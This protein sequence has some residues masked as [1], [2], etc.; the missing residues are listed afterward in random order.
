[1]AR[2]RPDPAL[3]NARI[4]VAKAR[5]ELLAAA[6]DA[7]PGLAAQALDL[8]RRRPWHGIGL[9]LAAGV[10]LGVGRARALRTLVP[11]V[12]PLVRSGWTQRSAAAA[13]VAKPTSSSSKRS[14]ASSRFSDRASSMRA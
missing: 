1:V 14:K 2:R 8:V 7:R 11:L 12:A 4:A 13:G 9:A 3:V 5:L 10:V 6:A